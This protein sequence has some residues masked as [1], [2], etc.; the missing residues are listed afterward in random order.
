MLSELSTK[1]NA[2]TSHELYNGNEN[3]LP[4]QGDRLLL[5]PLEHWQRPSSFTLAS[6]SN[7]ADQGRNQSQSCNGLGPASTPLQA[8]S[9]SV[10][11]VLRG[12]PRD[13]LEQDASAKRKRF[14]PSKPPR[15]PKPGERGVNSESVRNLDALVATAHR[16]KP[17]ALIS[18]VPPPAHRI[19]RWE[20]LE[21]IWAKLKARLS[22]Q[23]KADAFPPLVCVVEFDG[24]DDGERFFKVANFHVGFGE[25]LSDQQIQ[26]FKKWW[27]KLM[28]TESNQGRTFQYDSKERGDKLARYIAKDV[29]FRG[30]G[31]PRPVKWPPEWVPKRISNRLWF[32]RGLTNAGSKEGREI[33]RQRGMVRRHFPADRGLE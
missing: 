27:L 23:K 2:I 20:D 1:L 21:T 11:Y 15:S 8:A 16:L 33:N 19:T 26:S 18:L 31:G 6:A 17:V 10:E 12:R 32:S 14:V 13:K 7:R 5:G 3:S 30:R 28:E 9:K 25:R 22:Y 24:V 4:S 29:T